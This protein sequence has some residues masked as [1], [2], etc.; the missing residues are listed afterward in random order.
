[1]ITNQFQFLQILEAKLW[2]EHYIIVIIVQY[3]WFFLAPV[4]VHYRAM[5]YVNLDIYGNSP[6]KE[7]QQGIFL[8]KKLTADL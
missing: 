7:T 4:A 6:H 1:M 2:I 3:L 8:G 5:E